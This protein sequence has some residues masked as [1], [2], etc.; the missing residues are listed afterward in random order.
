[1][2]ISD[3]TVCNL[4]IDRVSGDRID[5][6]GE[7][8]P[9]GAFCQDNYPHK[10]EVLLGKYRWTFATSVALLARVEIQPGEVAP[11]AYKYAKPAD[12]VGAV[13][14]WR[15]AADPQRA[16]RVPYVIEADG[17]LWSDE[18]RIYVEYTADRPER[19][20][21]SWFRQL[22][23]TAFAA[24]LADHCQRAGLARDLRA[25]AFGTPGEGGEGGLYAQARNEDA[26][27]APQRQ[28]VSGID[29]GPLVGSRSGG[30]FGAFGFTGTR[31]WGDA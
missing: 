4:A 24:D 28:L 13:H 25:E 12:M 14:A 27:M 19:T 8:S 30:G 2:D 9:L 18:A 17:F 11:C 23:V 22:V 5:A 29:P 31:L 3:L 1:M 6:L 15:D 21:P 16:S 10:R 7:D 20:W 26:R